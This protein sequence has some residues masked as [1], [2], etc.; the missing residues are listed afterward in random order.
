M[1]DWFASER[2]RSFISAY[3]SKSHIL[4]VNPCHSSLFKKINRFGTY[5]EMSYC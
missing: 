1:D 2:K 5:V 4:L 3:E